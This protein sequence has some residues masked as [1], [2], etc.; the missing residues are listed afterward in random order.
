MKKKKDEK[1]QTDKEIN[2]VLLGR[3][4]MICRKKKSIETKIKSKCDKQ[5]DI[6]DHFY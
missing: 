6:S 4:N 1:A 5:F 3:S 2:L